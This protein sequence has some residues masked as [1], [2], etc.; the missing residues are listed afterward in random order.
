MTQEEIKEIK[1]KLDRMMT[2]LSGNGKKGFCERVRDNKN[3][4]YRM[5]EHCKRQHESKLKKWGPIAMQFVMMLIAI[6][7]VLLKI[8]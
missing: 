2:L 7:A 3:E 1:T 8:K 5:K 4:L 6:G